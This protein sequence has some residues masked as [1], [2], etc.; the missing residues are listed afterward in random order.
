MLSKHPK[1]ERASV[2]CG[3]IIIII[4]MKLRWAQKFTSFTQEAT[5]KDS[6]EIISEKSN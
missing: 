6:R 2:K 5:F 3:I 1:D 4:I